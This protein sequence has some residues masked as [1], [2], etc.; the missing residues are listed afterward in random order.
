MLALVEK[1]MTTNWKAKAEEIAARIAEHAATHDADDSFVTEGFAALDEAD[2]F[3]ALV[4]EEF[5]GGGAKISEVADALKIIGA[6]CGS[7][8][9]AAS[10]HS[11]IV[12]LAAW[13]FKHQAAPTDGLLKRVAAE[14]LRL[15]SSGGSDW[16]KSAGTMEKVEG[17]YRLT[18]RK[19]FA[20]GSPTGDLMST[21][22]V[23]DDPADGPTVLHFFVPLKG[24][25]V[26]IEPTW[27]TLGMRGTGSDDVVFDRAFIPDAA[28]AGKR[29]QSQWHMLFHMI[30]MIAFGIIYSAYLGVAEGARNRALEIIKKR[31]V[32]PILAQLVGE[33]ENRLL[34]A[35]LAHRRM[36]EI[37]ETGT[38]GPETTSE[39]MQCRTLVGQ[40]C[41]DTVTKAMEV[42]GGAAFYRKTGL[43]R[44]FRDIQ[45]ARFH[46][47]QEKQQLDLTGRTVL[48]W[49]IDAN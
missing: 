1:P 6:A 42:A 40:A 11:H 37:A 43:E 26:S 39:A 8:A 28:I 5:G 32:D 18:A 23:Y 19:A 16:L 29:P 15:V 10:M 48:G 21:S 24:E 14:R 3:A 12:A 7:T 41:I 2:F 31:P 36:I 27:R 49:P 20:S 25:G 17:G 9:L 46:P 13:R 35:K 44:A 22:A 45:A 38:P 30:S 33:M 34:V 4:P 47:M